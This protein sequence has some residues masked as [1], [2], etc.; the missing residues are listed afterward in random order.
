MM[1]RQPWLAIVLIVA[2]LL[3]SVAC[4]PAK[5]AAPVRG[6][7]D[8]TIRIGAILDFT[9]PLKAAAPAFEAGLMAWE[10]YVNE[11]GGI[12]GRKLQILIEDGE[13]APAATAA[14]ANKLIHN[15]Q[16]FALA[17]V[18]GSAA[19]EAV[20]DLIEEEKVPTIGLAFPESSYSPVKRH[21]F[22][23]GVPY[24]YQMA[25]GIDFLVDKF[26]ADLKLG[27][28]YQ[29][30]EMG[31]A[32]LI[33][34][35]DSAAAHGFTVVAAEAFP[36][37]AND[38]S[39]QVANLRRAGVNAIASASVAIQS[40]VLAQELA[41]IGW[42]AAVVTLNPSA[43]EVYFLL[44]GEA[45]DGMYAVDYL[46]KPGDPGYAFAKGLADEYDMPFNAFFLY[47]FSNIAMLTEAIKNA[48]STVTPDT[49]V[50]ALE[51][52]QGYDAH[53][54]TLPTY[55]SPTQRYPGTTTRVFEA[56]GFQWLEVAPL[57]APKAYE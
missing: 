41:K 2:M 12:N 27:V 10:R 38:L 14:A 55:F 23:A 1:R 30:D 45:A 28:L 34:V 8:E 7:T 16:V 5:K 26:G 47:T 21:I 3:L 18:L 20:Y 25:R 35:R 29:D 48:G 49:V 31:E 52:L 17:A 36:R 32:A 44:A 15:D 33:G 50:A 39:S 4:A 22:I 54:T 9:G 46:A 19:F 51:G 37:G 13:A 57:A 53:G 24:H 43:A 11:Q 56:S 6:V 42:D 40:A